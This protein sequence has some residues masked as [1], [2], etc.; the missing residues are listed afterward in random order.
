[1]SFVYLAL[2]PTH[3]FVLLFCYYLLMELQVIVPFS[4]QTLELLNVFG[5]HSEEVV[6]HRSSFYAVL[7]I[8]SIFSFMHLNSY[9]VLYKLLTVFFSKIHIQTTENIVSILHIVWLTT[10]ETF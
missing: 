2:S 9:V 10:I 7:F 5:Y 3:E 4:K 6:N 8:V 1:M